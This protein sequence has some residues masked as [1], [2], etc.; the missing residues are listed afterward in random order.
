[1]TPVDKLLDLLYRHRDEAHLGVP[2]SDDAIATAEGCL[3]VR[4]PPTYRRF[5]ATCGCGDLWGEEF[6]GLSAAGRGIPDAVWY[7][8]EQRKS[9]LP[10]QLLVVSA[11]DDALYCLDTG[12]VGPNGEAPII[13]W[14]PGVP[15]AKQPLRPQSASFADFALARLKE[16]AQR[17]PSRAW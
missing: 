13:E 11:D 6:Y 10:S 8:L 9:G 14:V 16:A 7:T 1:V 4:F 3:G 12:Q 15:L 2:M 5:I 17:K